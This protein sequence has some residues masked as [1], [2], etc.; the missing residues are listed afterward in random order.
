M[1]RKDLLLP[2]T[3]VSSYEFHKLQVLAAGLP[4]AAPCMCDQMKWKSDAGEKL[5]SCSASKWSFF[6]VRAMPL[7]ARNLPEGRFDF[8]VLQ[9]EFSGFAM[10]RINRKEGHVFRAVSS[11]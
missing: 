3:K 7:C 2:V 1:S 11:R 6:L 5:D 4:M 9:S 10:S 8:R